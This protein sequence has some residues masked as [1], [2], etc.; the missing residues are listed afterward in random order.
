MRRPA[1]VVG[2]TS[3]IIPKSMKVSFQPR[4]LGSAGT[5]VT[6]ILP[7]CGSAWKKPLLKSWSNITAAK[8]GATSAGSMPAR[9]SASVSV[10]LI[11]VTS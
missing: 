9:P 10:I 8:T 3:P 11:A 1:L 2:G 6:K 4:P 7:G 5:G